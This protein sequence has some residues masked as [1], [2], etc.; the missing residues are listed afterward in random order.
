MSHQA[1]LMFD[2]YYDAF[3]RN[4]FN[5]QERWTVRLADGRTVEGVPWA[6]SIISLSN[7]VF[8]FRETEGRTYS[9]PFGSLADAARVVVAGR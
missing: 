8:M 2:R 6:G 3:L 4:A 5:R 9:V 1:E 7:P